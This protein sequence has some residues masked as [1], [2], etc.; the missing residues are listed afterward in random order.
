MSVNETKDFESINQ[1]TSERRFVEETEGKCKEA[2]NS[3]KKAKVKKKAI[4]LLVVTCI[5]LMAAGYGIKGLEM[6]GWINNTFSNVLM[7]LAGAVAMFK[8]GYLFY[9]IKN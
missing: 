4:A 6:I 3:V 2:F 7:C 9:E 8:S 1:K 5:C